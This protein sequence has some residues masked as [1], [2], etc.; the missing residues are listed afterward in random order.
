MKV[1]DVEY[2][3]IIY[4]WWMVFKVGNEYVV[5]ILLSVNCGLCL[6]LIVVWGGNCV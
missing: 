3:F 1:I 2:W 4:V 5:I 6:S